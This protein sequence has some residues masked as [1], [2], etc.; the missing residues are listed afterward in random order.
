MGFVFLAC[1]WMVF[2]TVCDIRL[3]QK[4]DRAFV[5]ILGVIAPVMGWILSEF[6]INEAECAFPPTQFYQIISLWIVLSLAMHRAGGSADHIFDEQHQSW[7]S[8]RTICMF[9]FAVLYV[10][11][12]F[13]GIQMMAPDIF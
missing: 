8:D 10:V 13:R 1:F 12:E 5:I 7:I 11:Y 6:L 3:S 4:V 9:I 2:V